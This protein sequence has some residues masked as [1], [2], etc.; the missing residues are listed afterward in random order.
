MEEEQL[1]NA[2][3]CGADFRSRNLS[4][5]SNSLVACAALEHTVC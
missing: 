2:A 4:S 3:V 5:P 1:G